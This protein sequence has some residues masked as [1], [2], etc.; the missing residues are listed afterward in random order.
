MGELTMKNRK[1]I[2]LLLAI[3]FILT[4]CASN[5]IAPS[6]DTQETDDMEKLEENTVLEI[7]GI[8]IENVFLNTSGDRIVY[9]DL[10]QMLDPAWDIELVVIGEFVEET[11]TEITYE[12]FDYLEK[13]I[14]ADA[15]AYG[16]LRILE[17]LSGDIKVGE[18][19][20]VVKRYAIDKDNNEFIS[21]SES[22]PMHKGDRWIYFLIQNKD[23]PFE[24][25]YYSA[26]GPQGRH[27]VPNADI[28]RVVENSSKKTNEIKTYELGVF[29]RDSFDFVLYNEIINHFNLKAQDWVN[30][31]RSI[32]AKLIYTLEN[33]DMSRY[34]E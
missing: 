17:V 24:G 29:N 11:K 22:T 16:Q 33:Q 5:E 12:Y 9:R 31:G 1:I 2:A 13:E 18:T 32:D 19:I 4:S 27:P 6:S 10:E 28:M 20:T 14:R 30:P 25:T 3:T 15:N 7:D 26:G 23:E 21:Y 8:E 34:T